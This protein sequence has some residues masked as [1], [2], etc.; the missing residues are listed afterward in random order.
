MRPDSSSSLA[1]TAHRSTEEQAKCEAMLRE[2]FERQ[3]QFND[4]LGL[5]VASL[6]PDRPQLALAMRQDLV[7]NFV[8]YRLHGGVISAALDTVGGL[9]VAVALAEKHP[10]DSAEEVAHRFNRVGTIDLRTDY[11]HQ[12]M[13]QRFTATGR[14]IRMGGRI[15]SIQMSLVNDEGLLIATGCAS[16]VIS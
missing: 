8:H 7:G 3:I 15:A 13:G 14:I 11:L 5:K 4:I 12:G 6:K 1:K 2:L 10:G 16:Y 9:A